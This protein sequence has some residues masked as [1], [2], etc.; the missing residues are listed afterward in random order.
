[1]S[2]APTL[3][4]QILVLTK[5][6]LLQANN[7]EWEK[8]METQ[9]ERIELLV[10]LNGEVITPEEGAALQDKIL[11]I[12]QLDEEISKIAEEK[13]NKVS[14]EL[15]ELNENDKKDCKVSQ[16]YSQKD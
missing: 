11:E 2:N 8:M 12:Q 5:E 1:M 7:G 3:T 15:R 10:E 13:K 16:A 4:D 14:E 6:I 9:K